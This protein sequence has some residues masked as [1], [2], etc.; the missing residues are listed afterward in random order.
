[1]LQKFKKLSYVL[2]P[3]LILSLIVY[4][5]RD[6]DLSKLWSS[7]KRIGFQGAGLLFIGGLTAWSLRAL[8]LHRLLKTK[9]RV[10]FSKVFQA[11]MVG[12]L[13]D[14]FIPA[15]A[16]YLMRW[17]ILGIHEPKKKSHIFSALLSQLAME[18][19]S[20]GILMFIA[21]SLI[22]STDL[23]S[24]NLIYL[25]GALLFAG[26]IGCI[27]SSSL[28]NWLK[29]FNKAWL[30]P[31]VACLEMLQQARS[32][33]RLGLWLLIAALHWQLQVFMLQYCGSVLDLSL[34]WALCV[35][36]LFSIVLGI[37]VPLTPGNIGTIQLVISFV[38][39]KSGFPKEEAL[40]LGIL[41]HI[42]MLLPVLVSGILCLGFLQ[43][44]LLEFTK[45]RSK[46]AELETH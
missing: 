24:D 18:V 27:G 21:V 11:S 25:I 26:I 45:A 5:F 3:I 17:I 44:E 38:L 39:T 37:A 41:F 19:A 35:L 1:M 15:R 42:F 9:I 8:L 40:A 12:A 22:S 43:K 23:I 4:F 34:P 13:V 36:I 29:K 33:A 20:I 28:L 10:A 32:P 46:R 7:L 14:L 31:V 6:V 30:S 16:G 2:G